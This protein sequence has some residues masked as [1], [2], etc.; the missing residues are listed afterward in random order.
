M[1]P[2]A[3]TASPAEGTAT[4]SRSSPLPPPSWNSGEWCNERLVGFPSECLCVCFYRS[5]FS[6][7]RSVPFSGSPSFLKLC[8]S[9]I[10][11][12]YAKKSSKWVSI[13]WR[14]FY[15]PLVPTEHRRILHFFIF[16]HFFPVR[17][18]VLLRHSAVCAF[19]FIFSAV[20]FFPR[21]VQ[22][23]IDRIVCLAYLTFVKICARLRLNYFNGVKY[24]F[25]N[26]TV[27]FG[28]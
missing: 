6:I 23:H 19:S 20:V 12:K 5:G 26:K 22:P 3:R 24:S 2:R 1:G 17:K 28:L 21:F 18:R 15:G 27:Y 25:Q 11:P 9:V 8:H 16:T 7:F 10:T 13:L 4:G 14:F